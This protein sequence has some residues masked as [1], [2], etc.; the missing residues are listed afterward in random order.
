MARE[1]GMVGALSTV[2]ASFS[3]ASLAAGKQYA[4]PRYA[5][6]AKYEDF[7]QVASGLERLKG[8]VRGVNAP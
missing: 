3:P 4:L 5:Y 1:I 7:V 2:P 8:V 6:P